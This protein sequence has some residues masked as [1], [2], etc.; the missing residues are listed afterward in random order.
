MGH[1]VDLVAGR[2]ELAEPIGAGTAADVYTAID[3]VTGEH[4]AVKLAADRIEPEVARWRFEREAAA[5]AV[6]AS[7]HVV[8]LIA[9]GTTRHEQRPFLVL[10][11][12]RGRTLDDERLDGPIPPANVATWLGQ[13]AAALEL[14]HGLGIV[15][16]DLKPANLFLHEVGD[17]RILKV[18][19]F[20]LV[21]DASDAARPDGVVGTPLYMAP[22]QVRG[23]ASRIGPASDI[24][25]VAMV[26]ITLLT[27]ETYWTGDGAL[28][29]I[30]QIDGSPVTPPSMRWPWLPP[31]FDA[32]FAR[33]TARVAERRYKSVA[34]QAT[35]LARAL[36]GVVG[37][38]TGAGRHGRPRRGTLAD[39]PT[40]ARTPTPSLIPT[41]VRLTATGPRPLVGRDVERTAI[42]SR[43]AAGALVT[44]TG[45]SGVGKSRLA[46]AIAAATG[47]RLAD[48]AWVV[49]L[50]AIH[51]GAMLPEAIGHA[52]GL[53]P[54]TTRG[55][56]DQVAT[57][58]APRE[59]LIVLDGAEHLRDADAATAI[60]SLRAR[61]PRASWLVTSR[62]PLG[63]PDEQRI[64]LDPLDA[65][66]ADVSP[67][68]AW[69]YAAVELFV[70]RARGVD[71]TFSLDD[72]NVHDVV[73]ICRLVEGLP[74]G[75]ELAAAQVRAKNLAEIRARIE[76][77]RGGDDPLRG[78]VAWAY[79][80]LRPDHQA[81]LRH[82][83]VLP[84]GMTFPDLRARL[85]HVT[86][87]VAGAVMRLLESG[88]ASWSGD[89]P[90][91][92]TML[93]SVREL[94]RRASEDLRE[95]AAVW[96]VALDHLERLCARAE[97]GL[98]GAEQDRW[99][100]VLDAEH[101]NLRA[102]IGRALLVD[103]DAALHLAGRLTWYWYL[104]GHYEEGSTL[105][106]AALDR[107]PA[108]ASPHRL[109]ALHG[110]G[111]LALLGCSYDRAAELLAEARAMA[112][113]LGD[114]RGEAEAAQLSGSVA[115]E[116]GAYDDAWRLHRR[117]LALWLQ[118]GD[119][120][121]AARAR[122]YLAFLAW[123][124]APDGRPDEPV[125]SL[126]ETEAALTAL[127]D[128]EGKVW[129]QLNRAALAL[130]GGDVAGADTALQRAFADA[131]TAGYQEGIA[132]ALDL[133]GRA[134]ARRGDLLTARARL[135]ASLRVHRRLGDLWRCASVLD[136]LAAVMVDDERPARG[137][138]YLG[139]ADAIRRRLG[140]PVPA[141]EQPLRDEAERRGV[142]AIGDAYAVGRERGRRTPLDEI[143][144][145]AAE[146]L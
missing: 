76:L 131:V 117:A 17:A 112:A 74:L 99:L 93:D 59:A 75:L 69:R 21:K 88:L 133:G 97:A 101:D 128:L 63:L 90:P 83:A 144:A 52:L 104:R 111:R 126:D 71:P 98:R 120:R 37:D 50:G 92:L 45:P 67:D 87:D 61:C 103:P 5:L 38:G 95:D 80:L 10:E 121:E 110:A 66:A 107:A 91:R 2:F 86:D 116:R 35:A 29:V 49:P 100:G 43:L 62:V 4:V 48:G 138:V 26:A 32:W 54:D 3:L 109:A 115:R 8:R 16:R 11:R 122:N 96:E 22:E 9:A 114:V 81:L 55:A 124:A 135:H 57:A 137:A 46:A 44:V 25:A 14:A 58:L 84:A 140:T 27:G 102:A 47:D 1:P 143:V 28:E 142:A 7:P 105:L 20:G 23:Q 18:L 108:G 68:E 89:D 15:H 40:L 77:S 94:C 64:V 12:L 79:G 141:C 56:L 53:Q 130:Y 51:D 30:A 72:R 39:A 118:L 6:L 134:A 129:A 106:E 136:A 127:G 123:L 33:S 139:A 42:A 65:P 34:A 132:Y 73:A 119:P 125:P 85:G 82:L 146:L 60:D 41:G 70:E 24:W 19:D 113:A 145:M 78:A 36:A 13:A 31:A